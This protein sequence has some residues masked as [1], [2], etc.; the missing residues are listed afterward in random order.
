MLR[1]LPELKKVAVHISAWSIYIVLYA[2]LWRDSGKAFT[3]ALIY[4]V[5][6]LPPKI[7]L[8]Y[9][10]LVYLV[11]HFLAKKRYGIF[12]LGLLLLMTGAAVINQCYL[13]F[14][15]K[16]VGSESFWDFE[17]ISKRLTY[18]TSP[19]LVALTYEGIKM[20]AQLTKEKLNAEL[21]LLRNQ[22][23][24]HFFF[25]TLNNLYSLVLH[26]SEHAPELLLKL[27]G[28]MRYILYDSS[29]EAVRLEE[30]VNFINNYIAIEKI[31]YGKRVHVEWEVPYKLP[32]I[33]FPPLLLFTFIENAFKHGVAQEIGEAK[34]EAT[35]TIE[36][37]TLV[38]R[39]S[40]SL[41]PSPQGQKETTEG[42]G[43]KNTGQ[44]LQ[45]IYGSAHKFAFHKTASVFT[46]HLS[47]PI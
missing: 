25:N 7:I 44:R 27:S 21:A 11:P 1:P 18:L 46:A 38:Y 43:L 19:L 40:N 8:V 13:H 45:I 15:L 6:L 17:K 29:K 23:Q 26:K 12:V 35:L 14:M 42:I 2:T 30:E 41:P 3:E 36:H 39:V 16:S 10:C 22:L 32:P 5:E 37:N 31:R 33:Q 34:I 28:M 24:P 47:I 9:A 20:N 4:N